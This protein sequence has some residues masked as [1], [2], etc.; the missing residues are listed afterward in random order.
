MPPISSSTEWTVSV[1][2]S[3]LVDQAAERYPQLSGSLRRGAAQQCGIQ[4]PPVPVRLSAAAP[5]AG[6]LPQDELDLH[7]VLPRLRVLSRERRYRQLSSKEERFGYLLQ[8][9][10]PLHAVTLAQAGSW[11]AL[12]ARH[13]QPAEFTQPLSDFLAPDMAVSPAPHVAVQRGTT[14]LHQPDIPASYLEL[15]LRLDYLCSEATALWW[16]TSK[17]L[18][19]SQLQHLRRS[20]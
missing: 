14:Q 4:L 18:T 12:Y 17:D 1:R 20:P 15:R 10:A 2:Y 3:Y 16:L 19:P 8:A 5:E 7:R 9:G 13:V 6:L 11:G